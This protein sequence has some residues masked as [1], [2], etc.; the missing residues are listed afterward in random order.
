MRSG[1]PWYKFV[2]WKKAS[3]SLVK[4]DPVTIC[5]ATKA[6]LEKGT[7]I[8]FVSKTVVVGELDGI[9]LQEV[10]NT[11]QIIGW[12]KPHPVNELKHSSS[13]VKT[14]FNRTTGAIERVELQQNQGKE[15]PH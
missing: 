2:L 7:K 8:N 14:Y 4:H 9:T 13:F 15:N 3:F 12:M 6:A 1:G 10:G 11:Y 5:E